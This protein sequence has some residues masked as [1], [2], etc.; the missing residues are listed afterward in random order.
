M[1]ITFANCL[2]PDQ[3]LQ[4]V[5]LDPNYSHSV[6]EHGWTKRGCLMGGGALKA[7]SFNQVVQAVSGG[8]Y[9]GG[10]EPLLCGGPEFFSKSMSL[11]MHFKPFRSP[12]FHIL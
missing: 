5:C 7:E 8:E 12:F 6:P 9:E 2:D 3:D 11:R 1:L 4:N 10:I